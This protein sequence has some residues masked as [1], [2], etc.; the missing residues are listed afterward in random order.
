MRQIFRTIVIALSVAAGARVQAGPVLSGDGKRHALELPAMP[1]DPRPPS[2]PNFDLATPALRGL[3][4]NPG[5]T[6]PLVPPTASGT[7][8]RKAAKPENRADILNELFQRLSGSSDSAE[9][10]TI[11]V[12]IEHVWLQ[13]GSDTADLLMM[14]TVSAIGK[15]DSALAAK[16]LDR[17]V[18]IDPIWAEAWNKRATL[19]FLSGDDRGAMDDISHVLTL[20]PRH[21][22]ALSGMGFILQQNGMKK[23]ALA[24]IRR[25]AEIYPHNAELEKVLSNLTLDVEGRDI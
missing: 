16:L 21:F 25:A 7:A 15:G 19:R 11:A 9:A 18:S 10:G 2:L 5:V 6:M 12:S 3:A 24:I 14:R 1:G 20:E 8:D 13:S 22:G 17:I 23:Q 4:G